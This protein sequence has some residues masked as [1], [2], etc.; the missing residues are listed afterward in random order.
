[1]NATT[2]GIHPQHVLKAKIIAQ[3][4][5]DDLSSHG[6][7][8]PTPLADLFVST[9]RSDR[10]VVCHV[11][12]KDELSK[13][14]LEGGFVERLLVLWL[15]RRSQHSHNDQSKGLRTLPEYTGPISKR[16]GMRRQTSFLRSSAL[17]KLLYRR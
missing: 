5:V 14:R 7:E 3:D 2:T 15:R 6:D 1:M 9:A 11:D 13:Q 8:G 16:A 17:E 10:I 12:I 4:S